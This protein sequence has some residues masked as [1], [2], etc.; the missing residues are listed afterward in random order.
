MWWSARNCK[1][2]ASTRKGGGV[3]RGLPVADNLPISANNENLNLKEVLF[4][5]FLRPST[6]AGSLCYCITLVKVMYLV[7]LPSSCIREPSR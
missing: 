5:L 3:L 4:N 7:V 1:G 6:S 2:E